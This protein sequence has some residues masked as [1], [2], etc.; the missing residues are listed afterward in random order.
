MDELAERTGRRYRL[1]DYFGDPEAERV[2]VVMGSG[3]ETARETVDLPRR[4]RRAGRRAAGAAV[5]AVP[6]RRRCSRRCPRRC[7]SVAVL[8]RTKE[9]GSHG[10]PLFLDVRRRAGRGARARRAGRPCR[11]SSAAATACPRRSSRRRWSP[12]CSTSWRGQRRKRRFTIGIT[13]DVGGTSLAYDASLDIEPPDTR[14]RGVLRPRRGR[15]GRREQ[16]HASRSSATTRTCYAQGYFV[17]DSK[18]SGSQTVSHLRFGPQP[19]RAPYLVQPGRASSAATSSAC[20]TRSTCSACAA[21]GA[22]LLLNSPL[23]GRTRCGTRCRARCSSRSSTSSCGLYASTPTPVAREAGLPGRTNT[24]LQT[25]FFAIS[26]VLPRDE[27]IEQIK[28]AIRKTYGRRGDEVVQPQRGRR[29]RDAR[30][31]A[32]GAGPGGAHAPPASCRRVVPDRCARVRAHRH[33]GD[34]GR[35]RRRPAGQRAA[36]RRHLS[37]AARRPTRSA[38]SPSSSPSGTPTLCIQCGNCSFVCPHSVIRSKFYDGPALDGA[39][40]RLPVGAARRRRPARHP[41]HAAGLRRG[42]HRLRALR[43]GLPGQ[44][45]AA[46][47]PARRSTSRRGSR[48]LEPERENIALLR[49]AAGERPLAGRLRHRARHAVPRAAVRV[50]RR[51]RRA[52]ARRRTSSCSR[53]SSAT[54]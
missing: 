40:G 2:L 24:I 48:V 23:P 50:L 7:A 30:R 15:H 25:C 1:V 5:P 39:P 42:L 54:G 6:G 26:G 14:A 44:Q 10:E 3:G 19:I 4:A 46:T 41:L 34:D 52:A 11:G 36:G 43:R 33:G 27:A 13:D 21:D 9:P 8:D 29:R 38:T 20:S 47:R 49:D 22:T 12:A 32:R 35:P 37:R 17:Y 45:R 16:E 28:A 51:L 18:K 53:S 31:P